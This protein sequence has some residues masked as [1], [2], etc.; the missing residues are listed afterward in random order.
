MGLHNV[1]WSSIKG[2]THCHMII[3]EKNSKLSHD[4]HWW[5]CQLTLDS[6]WRGCLIIIWSSMKG[7]PQWHIILNEGHTTLS[8]DHQWKECLLKLNPQWIGLPHCYMILNEGNAT[9]KHDP[10]SFSTMSHDNQW[11]GCHLTLDPLWKVCHIFVWSWM[12]D[13]PHCH[14]IINERDSKFLHERQWRESH[15]ITWFSIKAMPHCHMIINKSDD[16]WHLILNERHATVSHDNQQMGWQL[17]LDPQ[18]MEC[19][20]VTWF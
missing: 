3:I 19:H 1:I 18:W 12:E 5:E 17:T 15:N 2:M 6:Q 9:L 8:H 11:M 4:Q 7:M 13:T 20:I 16:N 10:Q 14:M